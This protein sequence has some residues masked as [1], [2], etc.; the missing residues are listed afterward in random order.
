MRLN[1]EEEELPLEAQQ[2]WELLLSRPHV[3]IDTNVLYSGLRQGEH[4]FLTCNLT[5]S[6]RE[7][8]GAFLSNEITNAL[9]LSSLGCYVI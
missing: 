2:T 7:R 1:Y 9:Q 6:L 5:L 8:F 3:R 4:N